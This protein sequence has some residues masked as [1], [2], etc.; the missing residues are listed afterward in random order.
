MGVLPIVVP[1]RPKSSTKDKLDGYV[2][3]VKE[4][5][6]ELHADTN[7]IF[8]A[9]YLLSEKDHEQE[10]AIEKGKYVTI[11][12]GIRAYY[13]R[14]LSAVVQRFVRSVCRVSN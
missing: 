12:R 5:L 1:R 9:A 10:I 11:I 14:H 2:R 13:S 3:E 4:M 7:A 6:P 8:K